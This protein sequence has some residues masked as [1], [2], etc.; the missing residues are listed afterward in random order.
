M[1]TI[2][3]DEAYRLEVAKALSVARKDIR[4]MM[5]RVQKKI[6]YGKEE[7]NIYTFWLKKKVTQGV[8]VKVLLDITRR[9][10]LP[11]KQNFIL[12]REL[13]DAGVECRELRKNRVCHAKVV[14]VDERTMIIGSHNWTTN[15]IK[16]NL[17]VSLLVQDNFTIRRMVD[18]YDGIFSEAAKFS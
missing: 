15:S 3:L 16:R 6:G 5:F 7:G 9:P 2:I 18:K 11:Y 17:E 4:I 1:I 12:A 14:V 10:G 13:T 8:K